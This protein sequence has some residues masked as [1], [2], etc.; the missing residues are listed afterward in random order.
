MSCR[1]NFSINGA[2][3]QDIQVSNMTTSDRLTANEVNTCTLYAQKAVFETLVVPQFENASSAAIPLTLMLRDINADCEIHALDYISGDMR[4]TLVAPSAGTSWTWTLPTSAGADGQVLQ[5]DGTG[6]T[7]WVDIVGAN[8]P[9]VA[10]YTLVSVGGGVAEWTNNPTLSGNQFTLGATDIASTEFRLQS[11]NTGT[12]ALYF[13]DTVINRGG[14]TYNHATDTMSLIIDGI[15]AVTCNPTTFTFN[16]VLAID[17]VGTSTTTWTITGDPI[18]SLEVGNSYITYDNTSDTFTIGTNTGPQ[19]F[20][21]STPTLSTIPTEQINLGDSSIISSIVNFVTAPAGTAHIQFRESPLTDVT[22]NAVDGFQIVVE[23]VL[24]FH[25]DPGTNTTNIVGPLAINGDTLVLNIGCFYLDNVT[26][27]YQACNIVATGGNLFTT[28]AMGR[29][30]TVTD[31]TVCV[32]TGGAAA[33]YTVRVTNST[34]AASST[35]TTASTTT[36]AS[37]ALTGS[38]VVFT[39]GNLMAVE[40]LNSVGATNDIL[41]YIHG[42]PS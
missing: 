38:G 3:P 2:P 41:V 4:A 24:R 7:E 9:S 17:I 21:Q 20:F 23:D 6:I 13:D 10:G 42:F 25:I 18:S 35:G 19:I 34:T 31:V 14:I 40:A 5:T 36:S 37:V 32:A 16:D 39:A 1:P 8:V 15:A 29:N 22:Y 27:I 12:C 33:T 28:L 26:T 30:F 11:S